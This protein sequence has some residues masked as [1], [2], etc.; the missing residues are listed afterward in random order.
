MLKMI[1]WASFVSLWTIASILL[2]SV[3]LNATPYTTY[4]HVQLKIKDIIIFSLLQRKPHFLLN[5]LI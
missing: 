4:A 3:C 2:F 1:F 5:V